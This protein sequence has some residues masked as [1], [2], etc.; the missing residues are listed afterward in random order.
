MRKKNQCDLLPFFTG[1][2][3]QIRHDDKNALTASLE[4]KGAFD[5]KIDLAG[6]LL[7]F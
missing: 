6:T 4:K 7:Y 1:V 2:T 5:K 3:E